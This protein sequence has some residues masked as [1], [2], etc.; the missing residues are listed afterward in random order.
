M[1]PAISALFVYLDCQKFLDSHVRCYFTL[2]RAQ[3][4]KSTAYG[5]KQKDPIPIGGS[6]KLN[7]RKRWN[8]YIAFQRNIKENVKI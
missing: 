6:V 2:R 5:L 7:F 3:D 8:K 1:Y 4:N